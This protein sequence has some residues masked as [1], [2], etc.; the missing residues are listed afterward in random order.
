MFTLFIIHLF[1]FLHLTYVISKLYYY[2]SIIDSIIMKSVLLR[3]H[4]FISL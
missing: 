2:E 1:T 3:V 4:I